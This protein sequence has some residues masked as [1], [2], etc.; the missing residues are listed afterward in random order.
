MLEIFLNL[1]LFQ[2][3]WNFIVV[4]AHYNKKTDLASDYDY[5][6]VWHNSP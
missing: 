4:K 3:N 5:S 6:I 1:V 2:I